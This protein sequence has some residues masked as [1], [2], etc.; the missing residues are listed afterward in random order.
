[1]EEAERL[2][3]IHKRDHPDYKYQPRRRK[4]QQMKGAHGRDPQDSGDSPSRDHHHHLNQQPIN[5]SSRV[6]KHEELSPASPSSL[7][8]PRSSHGPPTPPTTPLMGDSN[9]SKMMNRAGQ[10]HTFHSLAEHLNGNGATFHTAGGSVEANVP[11]PQQSIDFSH[12]DMGQLSCDGIADD[13]A[14]PDGSELDRYLPPNNNNGGSASSSSPHT[15]FSHLLPNPASIWQRRG[16]PPEYLS[17]HTEVLHPSMR[18]HELLPSIKVENPYCPANPRASE[19][20]AFCNMEQRNRFHVK[21]CVH[22]NRF[23][24]Y[25][26]SAILS[27]PAANG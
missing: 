1:M 8:S 10:P 11:Q 19:C 20:N 26:H 24:I 5:Y 12:I 3:L 23:A 21:P 9:L 2:R 6:L 7:G 22:I 13:G 4:Q 25:Y 15:N 14:L 17:D 18:Y 16:D 27:V